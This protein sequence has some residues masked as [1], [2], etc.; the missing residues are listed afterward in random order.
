[1]SQIDRCLRVGGADLV[2]ASDDLAC[3]R[4]SC[5]ERTTR[6]ADTRDA[7]RCEQCVGFGRQGFADECLLA[8]RDG[9][10]KALLAG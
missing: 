1:M 2:D 7:K 9:H 3:D 8:G 10:G 5:G 6:V 4:G